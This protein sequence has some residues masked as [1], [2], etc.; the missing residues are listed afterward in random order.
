MSYQAAA[1]RCTYMHASHCMK[2]PAVSMLPPTLHPTLSPASTH[3]APL[4]QIFGVVC[5]EAWMDD[6]WGKLVVCVCL[7]CGTEVLDSATG[8]CSSPSYL[9]ACLALA[10]GVCLLA[11]FSLGVCL[12]A[13]CSQWVFDSADWRVLMPTVL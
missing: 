12:L 7:C 1:S 11:L 9:L 2:P 10:V 13:L 8:V 5:A 3:I 4:L 6:P